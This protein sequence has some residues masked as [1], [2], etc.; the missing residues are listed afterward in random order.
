M[1]TLQAK[2]KE[3]ENLTP[4]KEFVR[5]TVGAIC[6]VNFDEFWQEYGKWVVFKRNGCEPIKIMVN[7]LTNE[8]EIPHT[9]L[10]ESG[11]FQVGVFGVTE[12]ETLPTLYSDYIKIRYGTDTNSTT[13]PKYTPSEIDQLRLSKQ[14]KLT[15]GVGITI[16]ENNVISANGGTIKF[17]T[18]VELPEVGEE[19]VIY[20]L[21]NADS[22]EQNSYDEYIYTNGAWEKIGSA[23]VE[24][25][26][27]DY[28]K[29]TDIANAT[30]VG[31][32]KVK[33]FYGL[34]VSSDGAIL[35][36]VYATDKYA[37]RA[38]NILISKG[39]LENILAPLLARIEALENK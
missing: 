34:T 6:Q 17:R 2:E 16:S 9:I 12:T 36:M 8:I 25:D 32:V 29:K 30:T 20:L 4:D 31:V 7:S 39:T 27:T 37:T 13:P 21:P 23:S 15:A 3:I 14:D 1:L 35:G 5:G 33:D 24:V 19:N 26:L 11:E 18:V 22:Q 10:A 28:V 38:D